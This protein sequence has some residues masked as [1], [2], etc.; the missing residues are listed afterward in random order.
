[1]AVNWDWIIAALLIIG[2]ILTMWAKVS[3]QTVPELLRDLTEYFK[4]TREDLSE[5]RGIDLYE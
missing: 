2:L 1:M 4:D 3:K 5:S